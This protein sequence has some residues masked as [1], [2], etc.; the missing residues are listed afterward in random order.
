MSGRAV[1]MAIVHCHREIQAGSLVPILNGWR[2]PTRDLFCVTIKEKLKR[3]RTFMDWFVPRSISAGHQ[4]DRLISER[5]GLVIRRSHRSKTDRYH[6]AAGAKFR[7]LA[8]GHATEDRGV[9]TDARVLTGEAPDRDRLARDEKGA[10]RA[11]RTDRG[12]RTAGVPGVARG[13][14][15]DQ[16]GGCQSSGSFE[17]HAGIRLL[18]NSPQAS[19]ARRRSASTPAPSPS[20]RKSC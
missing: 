6:N 14:V 20:P 16:P 5:I 17:C 2:F 11:F 8:A 19:M 7:S 13:S 3:V 10:G 12:T 4:R 15:L 9:R 1:D 18:T